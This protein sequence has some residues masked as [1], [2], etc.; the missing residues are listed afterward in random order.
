MDEGRWLAAESGADSVEA[1][2]LALNPT[3]AGQLV[4]RSPL[5]VL[6]DV[7]ETEAPANVQWIGS[8]HHYNGRAG[9]EVVAIV[10]HTMAGSLAS[11]DSWFQ[12][13]RAQVSSHY[14]IGL[15]GQQHQYVALANGS[16]A[17]G[18][19]EPGN[20]WRHIVGNSVNPN[21]QTVTVE[22]EDQGKGSMAVTD[23][24]Y[25]GTLAVCRLALERYPRI[26]YLFGHRIISPNS[27]PN[28]CGDRWWESG[29]FQA[30]ADELSLEAY[31]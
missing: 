22:T 21:Y 9:C 12:N 16:F 3:W 20:Q 17:N 29:R 23:A 2:L 30:L 13:P 15:E 19:L 4:P 8:P 5:Y 28:C 26:T 6:P 27:R 24:Q 10:I 18:V 31:Y 7:P 25:A 1:W 14:G 11:C